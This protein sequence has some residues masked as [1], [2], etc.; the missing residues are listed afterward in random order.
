[1]VALYAFALP[2]ADNV[3]DVSLQVICTDEAAALLKR[4]VPVVEYPRGTLPSGLTF[5]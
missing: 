2:D 5:K 3:T 1:M 4:T